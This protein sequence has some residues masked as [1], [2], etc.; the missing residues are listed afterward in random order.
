MCGD[1]N[2]E[3]RRRVL[4]PHNDEN[5][6]YGWLRAPVKSLEAQWLLVAEACNHPNC[7]VLPFKLELIRV[8]AQAACEVKGPRLGIASA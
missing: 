4:E 5:D 6:K 3:E 1:P 8:A 7:L 2:S